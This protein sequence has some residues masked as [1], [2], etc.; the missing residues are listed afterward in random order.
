MA[1][2][3]DDKITKKVISSVV[4]SGTIQPGSIVVLGFSGGPDSLCLLH[5]L[6]TLSDAL[7]LTIIPVHV[8]HK[9]RGAK[10]DQEEMNAVSICEK[11]DLT[12]HVFDADCAGLAEELS[13]STE[14]AG[15]IIRYEIFDAVASAIESGGPE[16]FGTNLD[17]NSVMNFDKYSAMSLDFDENSFKDYEANFDDNFDEEHFNDDLDEDFDEDFD[18][19]DFDDF[20]DFDD[21]FDE[22]GDKRIVI[23][24]AHNADDQSETV[25]FRLL[26]GTGVHGLAGM[27]NERFSEQGFKIVRPLLDVSRADIESYIKAN[28]LKPNMDESNNE[29]DY[30]RNKIRLELIPY[31][32]KEFNPNIK[33]AL[34][35]YATIAEIED[36]FMEQVS[37]HACLDAMEKEIKDDCISLKLNELRDMPYAILRR[38][39]VLA[40]SL[41]GLSDGASFE[42][43]ANVVSLIYSENP[44]AQINLPNGF[45]ACR[46]YNS[47]VFR[48]ADAD[49]KPDPCEGLRLMPQIM[50]IKSFAHSDDELYAVFDFDAF[51][52][53][54]PGKVGE[55]KLRTRREGDYIAI[56]DGKSKKLQDY[57][58][59]SKIPKALRDDIIVVAIGNEVLWIIP[60]PNLPTAQQRNK[61][62]Y[63]Q[64]YQINDT[65]ERVLFLELVD[66]L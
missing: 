31:L 42:L 39:A 51:N 65:T 50:M 47:I 8:N 10:A 32:E 21:D 33:E 60:N 63:S 34:R 6:Y 57:F 20:D 13:I 27:S 36:S 44:S 5:A 38:V 48:K 26:R 46:E 23:A 9:L 52:E 45:I 17:M 49:D 3:K 18:E 59:D 61:G 41:L 40:L 19:E 7:G 56:K 54:Y 22:G 55:L 53:K 2:R 28:K 66:F 12:C 37:Y 4:E 15:R 24:V 62:K 35:R 43:V 64:N 1:T 11:M 58:V 16:A 29:T 30:T 14:E 25:L